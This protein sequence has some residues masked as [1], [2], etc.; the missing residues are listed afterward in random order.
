MAQASRSLRPYSSGAKREIEETYGRIH[1]DYEPIDGWTWNWHARIGR[2]LHRSSI[3][4]QVLLSPKLNQAYL[5]RKNNT[6]NNFPNVQDPITQL[7][8]IS[9]HNERPLPWRS[10]DGRFIS[11]MYGDGYQHPLPFDILLKAPQKAW[12]GSSSNF[13]L[14]LEPSFISLFL[15]C[16]PFDCPYH[17]SE[18]MRA[19]HWQSWRWIPNPR[20]RIQAKRQK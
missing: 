15:V 8:N 19:L 1:E 13:N 10:Q 9:L 3:Y 16:S 2:C 4:L 7:P 17:H 18:P 6:N 11:D 20:W 5:V 12:E 14:P